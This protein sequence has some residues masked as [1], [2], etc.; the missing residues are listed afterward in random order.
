MNVSL[1]TIALA[2]AITFG[3]SAA[4]SVAYAGPPWISI[5]FPTNPHN[6]PVR[7]ARFLVRTYHHWQPVETA[8]TGTAE[9][10]VN[11]VRRSIRLEFTKGP[12]PGVYGVTGN[13]P[14]EGAWMIVV[15]APSLDNATALVSLGVDGQ[16]AGADVPANTSNDGWKIP[17][18][19]TDA[20]IEGA[21]RK[22]AAQ[23]A[24]ADQTAPLGWSLALLGLLAAVPLGVIRRR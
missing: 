8:L 1:R 12:V 10:L 18:Q 16:V 22:H 24:A 3:I 7:G 21:L 6:S 14:A 11:G 15:R 23:L 2:G 20:E 13:I 4:A 5:E 9:G 19:A 17:R